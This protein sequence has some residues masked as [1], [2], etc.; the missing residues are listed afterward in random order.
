MDSSQVK[1]ATF[2]GY[3]KEQFHLSHG[4]GTHT[5]ALSGALLTQM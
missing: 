2:L 1:T 5:T 4:E 3:W